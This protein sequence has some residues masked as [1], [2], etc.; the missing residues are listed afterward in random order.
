MIIP[1]RLGLR[2]RQVKDFD[3]LSQPVSDFDRLNQQVGDFDR[4]NRP[5]E[6]STGSIG[7]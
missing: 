5:S 3:K 6:I 4:L 1:P 2:G 7:S